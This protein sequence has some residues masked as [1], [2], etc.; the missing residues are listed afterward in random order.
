MKTLTRADIL[1]A[2]D[3][4]SE[5]VP[6][7]EWGGEVTVQELTAA[8]RDEFE[9]SVVTATGTSIS[10]NSRN[11]TARLVALSIVDEK[12]ER[13]F[14]DKDIKELGKK[15]AKALK[16]V[17]NAAQKLSAIGEDEL[18]EL[19]KDSGQTPSVASASI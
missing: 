11:M 4:K 1:G 18:E 3:L 13:M 15:S 10:Y 14:S 7:P 12:G 6:V 8:A 9:S 5:R 2:E 19:G 16:R 17:F